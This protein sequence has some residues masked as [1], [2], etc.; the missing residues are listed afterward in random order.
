MRMHLDYKNAAKPD[1]GNEAGQRGVVLIVALIMLVII[2]LLASFSIRNATST[3]AV[4]GNVRTTQLATQAAEAA[5]QYCEDGVKQQFSTTPTI[6][7]TPYIQAYQNPPQW[8]DLTLWDGD[9]SVTAV[10]AN[11]VLVIPTTVLGNT[12]TFK[13]LP[14]CLIER[15]Q[16]VNSSNVIDNTSTFLITARGFGPEVAEDLAHRLRPGGGEVWLQSTLEFE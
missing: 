6:V 1:G 12:A 9:T 15:I 11:K 5:L 3:E 10:A 14:E 7:I 13:R 16:V 4:S 8:K 2:S